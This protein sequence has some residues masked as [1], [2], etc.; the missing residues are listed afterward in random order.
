MSAGAYDITCEQGATFSRTLTVKDSS[1]AV[2]DL[3]TYTARMQV[4][5]TQSSSSTLI[6]LTTENGRISLNSSGQVALSISATD[7]AS[8]SDGGIYDLELVSSGGDVERLVEGNF[9]LVL[10][11]TR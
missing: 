1:G 11:V 4:R 7:T 6:E 2:R 8:L 5:R 9:T 3:S 10:E